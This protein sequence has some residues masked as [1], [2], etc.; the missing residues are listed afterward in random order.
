MK[1]HLGRKFFACLSGLVLVPFI[2]FT[3]GNVNNGA[4]TSLSTIWCML[5]EV[6]ILFAYVGGN[7]W[8]KWI[9]ARFWGKGNVE[10][11]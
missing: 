4:V 9:N 7:V 3:A 11:N 6:T 8:S 10:V 1:I 5:L 2:F